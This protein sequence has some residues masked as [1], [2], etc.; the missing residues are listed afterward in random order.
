[1]SYEHLVCAC[2]EAAAK[3][4]RRVLPPGQPLQQVNMKLHS[5]LG[6]APLAH[7]W[8]RASGDGQ[9]LSSLW[10]PASPFLQF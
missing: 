2:L 10:V 9:G 1:M 5:Q 6:L 7:S 4:G 8:T 3:R